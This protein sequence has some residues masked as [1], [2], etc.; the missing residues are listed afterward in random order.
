MFIVRHDDHEYGAEIRDQEPK[1][2]L[3]SHSGCQKGRKDKIYAL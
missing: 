2:D 3:D 1:D